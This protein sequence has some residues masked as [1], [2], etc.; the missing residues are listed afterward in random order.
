MRGIMRTKSGPE[1]QFVRKAAL[2]SMVLLFLSTCMSGRTGYPDK[3][4]QEGQEECNTFAGS[5]SLSGAR[6]FLISE[7][8][9]HAISEY[10]FLL[11][12]DVTNAV[13]NAEYAYALALN[14]IYDAALARLD[15]VWNVSS[16]I[17]EVN[18]FTSQ[19]FALMGYD[20]LAA[21]IGN[22]LAENNNPAWI[23]S[24]A[25]SL[26]EKYRDRSPGNNFPGDRDVVTSFR[27]ANRFAAQ[28]YN[29]MAIAAFEGIVTAYPGEYL[30]YLG[31]S[32]ALEKAGLFNKSIETLEQ[33]NTL[34]L[35]R[36]DGTEAQKIIEQRLSQ[37]RSEALAPQKNP[38]AETDKTKTVT[39]GRRMLAYAGGIF[40]NTF[41]SVNARFGT[42]ITDAGSLSADLGLAKSG[43][44]TSL[45]LGVMN[46]YRQKVFVAGYGLSAGFGSQGST[47][48]F[49]ISAGLSFMNKDRSS[50][51]DIFI[52]GQQPIAPK[53]SATTMG[54][55]VGR[56]VYFGTR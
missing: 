27:R 54:L 13:L 48:S 49:K 36:P 52:D 44:S 35:D 17:N 19:V 16:N 28:N 30:P 5:P 42:F 10:A 23:A 25:P 33:A 22:R 6:G 15:K 51:W 4:L 3:D 1:D 21:E 7:D 20:A 18:Y 2:F 38:S 46:F 32:T 24:Y 11:R 53:G 26:L 31:Y 41:V 39:G 40:S 55:S 12:E 45:N 37:V 43:E 50:S 8:F 9:D 29:L 47:L 34:V 14:G 56:S